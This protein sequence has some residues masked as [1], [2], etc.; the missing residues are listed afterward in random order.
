[1]TNEII[2]MFQRNLVLI[3][4]VKYSGLI[5]HISLCSISLQY[6]LLLFQTPQKHNTKFTAAAGISRTDNDVQGNVIK[7]KRM[8]GNNGG[9][10]ASL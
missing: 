9:D 8:T 4:L 10:S 3:L 5:L 1:M 2:D 7:N 6:S